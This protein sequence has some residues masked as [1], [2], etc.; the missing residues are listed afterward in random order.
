MKTPRQIIGEGK[1]LRVV[2]A[3][4]W[5]FAERVIGTS[6]VAI[7]ATFD[8]RLIFTEQPRRA[9]Q[10]TVIE[11]PAGLVGDIADQTDEKLEEAAERELFEETGYMA[12]KLSY[13]MGGPCSAGLTNEIVHFY[14]AEA[15]EKKGAGGGDESEDITVHE[16]PLSDVEGWLDA[17]RARG[18]L[19]DPKVYI[20]FYALRK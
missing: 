9:V 13:L 3:D 5:E 20:A 10:T 18:A 7:V 16:I 15:L 19:V 4:G 12:G 14:L 2:K 17:C 1:Y 6:V 11:L 8:G